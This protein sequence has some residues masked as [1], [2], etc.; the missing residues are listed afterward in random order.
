MEVDRGKGAEAPAVFPGD[1]LG[2]TVLLFNRLTSLSF[3]P[4]PALLI[5]VVRHL[6]RLKGPLHSRQTNTS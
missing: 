2:G 4:A 1:P 5:L 3:S 6:L